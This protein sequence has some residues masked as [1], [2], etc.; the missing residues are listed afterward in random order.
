MILL[1]GILVKK[2]TAE[3]MNAGKCHKII[4]SRIPCVFKMAG[5]VMK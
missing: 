4:Q 1:S 2:N 5:A 3:H